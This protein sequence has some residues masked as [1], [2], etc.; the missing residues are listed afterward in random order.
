[1]NKTRLLWCHQ[2]AWYLP[3]VKHVK[4]YPLYPLSNLQKKSTL[5]HFLTVELHTIGQ[6]RSECWKVLKKLARAWLAWLCWKCLNWLQYRVQPTKPGIPDRDKIQQV[7]ILSQ[8][9]SD[10]ILLPSRS[11][12]Y[13]GTDNVRLTVKATLF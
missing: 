13:Q 11:G 5:Y 8:Y 4:F 10:I 9:I 7:K 12:G 6:S 2:L 3:L 1:M